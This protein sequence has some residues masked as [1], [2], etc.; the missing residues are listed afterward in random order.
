MPP[1]YSKELLTLFI[2]HAGQFRQKRTSPCEAKCLVGSAIQKVHTLLADGKVDEA[3]LW[4]HARNPFPGVTGRVCPH[5]CEGACNRAKHDEAMAIQSLERFAAD[6]G[7][8]AAIKPMAASGKKIAII[9]SGPTGLSA[10]RFSALFGHS[11]DVYES[12]PV[13]GGV[14]R[15]AIPD[16]RLPKDVVDRETGAAIEGNVNVITNITVGRDITLS[17]IMP[18]YD[19]CL[20]AVGL[21]KERILNI[22]GK[23]YLQTAVSWLKRMTLD[24]ENFEGR[25]VAIL[26][27]GGVAFDCAFTA[28]R[29]KARSVHLLCLEDDTCMRAPAEEVVQA[30]E[31]G[32]FLHQS[33]LS[34]AV[35]ANGGRF[36]VKADKVKSFHFDE[37]GALHV[38]PAG[39]P[40]FVL[41]ADCVICASGLMLDDTVLAGVEL[42]RTPRGMVKVDERFRTSVPG[43]FAAGDMASGPGLVGAAVQSGRKAALSIHRAI[44]GQEEELEVFIDGECRVAMRPAAEPVTPHVVDAEEM[45]NISYHEHAPREQR[46]KLSPVP[47][48]AFTELEGGLSPEQ[49]V[50]EASRCMHCGH[51]MECG[52]CVESCPG[53]ILE[54]G[55]DGPFVAYPT[56]CWHCGCCRIACPTGSV[57]YKFPLTMML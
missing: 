54:L 53:H 56:Q 49:A 41:D 29:L 33:L 28:R 32:I 26:G 11:V 19:A 44:M 21:W 2:Q 15:Q 27:G 48:I 14:P 20:M 37:R 39:E 16:F 17:E 50:R 8:S 10:A 34:K 1:I 24:R 23:E 22:T 9:G 13:M 6:N 55:E 36:V 18:R 25:D 38:E 52:S 51:C 7:R 47:G 42:E 3:L 35:E 46:P 43:L 31:E 12:S 40:E 45:M 57:A 30:R 4:L 5:P